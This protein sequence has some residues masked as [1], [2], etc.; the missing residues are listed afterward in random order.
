[1]YIDASLVM[2]DAQ[3]ITT[4]ASTSY[5]DTLAAGEANVAPWVDFLVDTAM[6]AAGTTTVTFQLQ[7]SNATTFIDPLDVTL[8]ATSAIPS[9]TLVAGYRILRQRLPLGARRYIRGYMVVNTTGGAI[10]A[11]KVDMRLVKD[12]DIT[13]V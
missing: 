13:I 6:S 10:S 8:L 9:A 1:M 11:G 5:I 3:T 4:G 2:A 7:S 12:E